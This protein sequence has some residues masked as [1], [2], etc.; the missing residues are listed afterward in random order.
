MPAAEDLRTEARETTLNL[1]LAL[2]PLD[3]HIVAS[4]HEQ[5]DVGLVI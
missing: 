5:I 2:P 1:Q 4:R 3:A